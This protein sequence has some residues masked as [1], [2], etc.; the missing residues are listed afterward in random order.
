MAAT[1]TCL[2]EVRAGVSEAIGGRAEAD[3]PAT[4]FEPRC[5]P[6]PQTVDS[7][8]NYVIGHGSAFCKPLLRSVLADAATKLRTD[9]ETR[10]RHIEW[11]M[12]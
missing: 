10:M 9:P 8:K 1:A 6:L 3:H 5:A 2:A 12:A 11:L 7:P 4:G